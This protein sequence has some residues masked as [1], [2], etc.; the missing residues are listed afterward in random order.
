MKLNKLS[1]YALKLYVQS[2]PNPKQLIAFD[3]G[4]KHTGCAISCMNLKKSYVRLD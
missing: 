2:Q 4:T 1:Q 3:I